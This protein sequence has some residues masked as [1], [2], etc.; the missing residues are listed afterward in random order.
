[1]IYFLASTA[2]PDGVDNVWSH[3]AALLLS[4]SGWRHC[5][6]RLSVTRVRGRTQ[7][8]IIG[9]IRTRRLGNTRC[10]CHTS[11]NTSAVLS[12]CKR[13]STRITVGLV[14]CIAV[15]R[16]FWR[17]P[18]TIKTLVFRF[19]CLLNLRRNSAQGQTTSP[20]FTWRHPEGTW[21][22]TWKSKTLDH[23]GRDKT[24]RK[25]LQVCCAI[26][27]AR[28]DSHACG[29]RNFGSRFSACKKT[30][31]G[32]FLSALAQICTKVLLTVHQSLSR[33]LRST[34]FLGR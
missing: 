22:A 28:S 13:F 1:M 17:E 15:W 9:V 18:Q 34:R 31:I 21:D 33:S 6:C 32:R 7:A 10:C 11:S 26:F 27:R 3:E 23:H 19:K 25:A 12:L 16:G 29:S 24:K 4:R 2:M 14:I 5:R 8:L 30:V 20:I